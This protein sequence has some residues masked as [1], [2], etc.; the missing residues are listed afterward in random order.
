MDAR[1]RRLLEV[2]SCPLALWMAL[3]MSFAQAH[4]AGQILQMVTEWTGVAHLWVIL[5]PYG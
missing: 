5:S 3:P 2:K 4:T 1:I